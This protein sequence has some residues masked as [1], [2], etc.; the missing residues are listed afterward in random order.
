[1]F[2]FYVGFVGFRFFMVVPWRWCRGGA[3][4]MV[5]F[6]LVWF[7]VF[8]FLF[9]F[10]FVVVGFVGFGFVGILM[11]G[12]VANSNGSIVVVVV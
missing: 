10:F 4:V 6:E 1:M 7:F 2:G 3:A 9:F 11:G 8:C 12:V 5:R